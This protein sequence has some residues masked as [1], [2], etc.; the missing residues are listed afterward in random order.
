VDLAKRDAQAAAE[1]LFRRQETIGIDPNKRY[2]PIDQKDIEK[3]D[4]SLFR[5][6]IYNFQDEDD[7]VNQLQK[8]V[9]SLGG[10]LTDASNMYEDKNHSYYR[11]TDAQKKFEDNE[12]KNI[13]SAYNKIINSNRLELIQAKW[14][15]VIKDNKDFKDLTGRHGNIFVFPSEI[16]KAI[17]HFFFNF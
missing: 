5:K 10:K 16:G 3:I 8:Q 12:M 17:F 9:V 2:N 6:F 7:P 4:N 14:V 15:K 1:E 11:A 13:V